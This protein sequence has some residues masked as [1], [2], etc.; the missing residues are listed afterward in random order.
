MDGERNRSDAHAADA[1][2]ALG[3]VG[4][5]ERASGEASG[6]DL[7]HQQCALG[8][9]SVF[10]VPAGADRVPRL[11]AVASDTEAYGERNADDPNSAAADEWICAGDDGVVIIPERGRVGPTY[12]L[13]S[14]LRNLQLMQD[15]RNPSN[16]ATGAVSTKTAIYQSACGCRSKTIRGRGE[17]FP[18]CLRCQSKVDWELVQELP[19][20]DPGSTSP[21]KDRNRNGKHA[22][23]QHPPAPP[24]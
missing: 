17:V 23:I 21:S 8:D 5:S 13:L 4:R 19:I 22:A 14:D 11:A 18:C 6:S 16:S 12:R 3:C 24:W 9:T 2:G 7:L 20:L 1:L 15:D 10:R